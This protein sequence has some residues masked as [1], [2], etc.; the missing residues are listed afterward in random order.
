MKKLSLEIVSRALKLPVCEGDSLAEKIEEAGIPLSTYCRKRG[1]CGKCFV[2]IVRGDIPPPTEKESL[3]MR[4]KK[5]PARSRLSCLY[6]IRGSLAV[7]IP[8]GSLFRET[9]ILTTGLRMSVVVNPPVKKYLL[10][11]LSPRILN[12]ASA[13]ELVEEGLKRKGLRVPL[14]LLRKLPALLQ[15]TQGRLTAVIFDEE[16]I[17]ALEAGDTTGKNYGIAI[18]LGTTTV[19]VELVDLQTGAT[20]DLAT[21]LNSQS[22]FGSDVV[23]RISHAF[24]SDQNL[25]DLRLSIV[26]QL[27]SLIHEMGE[28]N[29]IPKSSLYEVVVAGNTTMNHLLL[30]LPVKTLAVA[31]FN[32]V[33][34]SLDEFPAI[35][36]GLELNE[37]AKA[38]IV[39]NIKSFVGG[40][41]SAGILA[42]DL[43]RRPGNFV[44]IDLGTNGE[45]VLKKGKSLWATS[46]AAG[47]AFE[48][49]NISSG[50]LALPGAIYKA[51]LGKKLDVFTI[52][53]R[54]PIG[55]CGT[56]LIDLLALFKK[57]GDITPQGKIVPASRILPV[58]E[59]ITI[60]QK[61]VREVQ[62]AIAAVKTGVRMMLEKGGL[63]PE[64]LDGILIAGAFG[65]YLNV[66]NSQAIGLLPAIARKKIVFIGNASLSGA[67]ELLLSSPS[68][69]FLKK[70]IKSVTHVSLA[71][72]PE[73]QKKFIESLEFPEVDP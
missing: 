71:A 18:D 63:D 16:E 66:R 46:T 31:P 54:A 13:L 30:G 27:N 32:A 41:I 68:R 53:D 67:K 33:F 70:M 39:P 15:D 4:Q 64:D 56:G 3:L 49:M 40:D 24:L 35:E 21:A 58:T 50:M 73:F 38:F 5:M 47:P 60:T 23:S 57:K 51:E 42:S 20:V 29:H 11:V 25:E 26:R 36:L 14:P 61:D 62:L 17:L 65:N 7:K 55:I 69:K 10:K 44:F 28:R 43:A 6:K 37:Q 72:D 2:E 48:G 59:G 34:S 12:P 1:V 52:G 22:R 9:N 45:I 8:R 19:V